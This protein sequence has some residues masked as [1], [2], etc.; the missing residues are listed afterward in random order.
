M[1][2]AITQAR[3]DD[4]RRRQEPLSRL[5]RL[6]PHLGWRPD[7][8]ELRVVRRIARS[9]GTELA[10]RPGP[11]A[12]GFRRPAAAWAPRC[13]AP[14]PP[15]T[16]ARPGGGPNVGTSP[17]NSGTGCTN[18]Y[19]L[20]LGTGQ[21]WDPGLERARRRSAA[22]SARSTSRLVELQHC[23][24]IR[25]PTASG[26]S[27]IPTISA[28][29]TRLRSAT[30]ARITVDQ[31][32][33]EQ[34][35]VLRLG[36]LQHSPRA[37]PEPV[38]PEPGGDQ[39]RSPASRSRPSTP[40]IRRR[41]P[42]QSARQL[43]SW[44]VES[45]RITASYELAQRYQFGLNI[46]LPADWSGRVWYSM[47]KD[48][49]LQHHQGTTE[50]DR[51]V[52]GSWAGRSARSA[53]AGT[54]PAIGTWTKPANIPYLNLFCDPHGLHMQLAD[55]T[56]AYIQAIRNFNER[57]WINEK[58][59][60]VRRPAVRSAG[61][62]GQGGHRREPSPASSFRPSCVDN[63]DASNLIV[64]YQQDAQGR[65]V[66]AV[67]TQINIPIFSE[68]NALPLLA[69]AGVRSSPGVMTS[70]ATSAAPAIRRW[71]STGR[72]STISPSAAPGAPR[73]ARRCSAS[74]RRSP[75]SRLPART[76]AALR[77]RRSP[78]SPAAC[79]RRLPPVGSGAWKLHE[80]WPAE[81]HAGKCNRLPDRDPHLRGSVPTSS[82]RASP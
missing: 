60:E 37:V 12:L 29:T 67:F 7:H 62:H 9:T 16:A 19:S 53:P 20:P 70:T 21:N 61:R 38:E 78:S 34:H 33:T 40:T 51:G 14:S 59:I 41:R 2:G 28:G 25:A 68:Q 56:L 44:A 32:L 17:R 75:T 63:T 3:L 39:R 45:P 49:E 6:G 50:Q 23:R 35:L 46:A 4:G 58:G 36:L 5:G 24:A 18:C 47:T 8:A 26:T 1:D 65:Q 81:R 48:A 66:W 22:A 54:T 11:S 69:P 72:R 57:F 71:R 82:R 43:Q 30:A 74:S 77:T 27:S 10:V 55:T 13:P 79:R 31:R 42:G 76:L 80:L 73:S 64:P 52:R 15:A